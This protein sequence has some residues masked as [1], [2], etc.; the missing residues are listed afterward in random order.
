VERVA[1]A[2]W[3]HIVAGASRD[4][5]AEVALIDTRAVNRRGQHLALR[6]NPERLDAFL[7]VRACA[8]HIARRAEVDH[9]IV[10][11]LRVVGHIAR[12][13]GRSQLPALPVRG[14]NHSL[15]TTFPTA[16]HIGV[17]AQQHGE[18][19]RRLLCACLVQRGHKQQRVVNHDWRGDLPVGSAGRGG[20]R[21]GDWRPS[22]LPLRRYASLRIARQ[23]PVAAHLRHL[24]VDQHD[25]L[26][27]AWGLHH[28]R[29]RRLPAK[30]TCHTL[31]K[32]SPRS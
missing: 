6:A 27:P 11:A 2:A 12:R 1:D 17:I 20:G 24:R 18:E 4:A 7:L 13:S 23:R 5:R 9:N 3:G 8:A 26:Q 22:V 30:V 19:A 25:H 32:L 29:R 28:H 21:Q 15:G 10:A 16:H 14:W 31:S